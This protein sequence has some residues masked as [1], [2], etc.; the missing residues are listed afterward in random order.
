[1]EQRVQED[2]PRAKISIN[3]QAIFNLV[4][5]S[6]DMNTCIKVSGTPPKGFSTRDL[7]LTIGTTN[8]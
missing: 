2:F 8:I 6:N 7:A 3:G 1:M 4:T 5:I